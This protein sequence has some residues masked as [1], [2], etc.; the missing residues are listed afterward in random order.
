MNLTKCLDKHYMDFLAYL[1]GME[2]SGLKLYDLLGAVRRGEL[3]IADCYVF[4]AR[5]YDILEGSLGDP[6]AALFKLS[7][8]IQGSKL[9][10]LLRG[11]GSALF[12][13]GDTGSF[14]TAALKSE[15]SFFRTK[16]S[17][18]LRLIEVL[19]E[20]ML[21]A[22]LCVSMFSILPIWPLPPA[23]GVLVLQS[24][25]L[26]GFTVANRVARKLLYS[27]ETLIVLLEASYIV[28]S[29]VPAMFTYYGL[30]AY[31]L[32]IVFAHFLIHRRL[33][34][35][36]FI[37][38]ESLRVL[39]DVH[40]YVMLG[41]MPDVALLSALGGAQGFEFRVMQH[42]LLNGLFG[43]EI[44]SKLRLPGLANDI[45]HKLTSLMHYSAFN[46]AYVASIMQYADEISEVR[47]LA[48]VKAKN[49]LLYS[50]VISFL[51]IASYIM[52]SKIP[53]LLNINPKVL[54]LYGFTSIISAIAP[55]CILKDRSFMGSRTAVVATTTAT[56]IP[57]LFN[58][59]P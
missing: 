5:L 41:E 42:G 20:A 21:A 7:E 24:I 47:K 32:F 45:M 22:I 33:K 10:G 37:E 30:A 40:S 17:E 1:H 6:K 31:L 26:M 53:A 3:K 27:R 18:E 55:T 19:Y 2:V 48:E 28:L 57:L 39:R 38:R 46:G 44:V 52:I 43:R 15:F 59:M 51:V 58:I 23:I 34:N 29:I 13:S 11:Y 49:Y 25:G 16:I 50:I 8:F 14:V 36:V 35:E 54:G 9:V 4:I 56:A 12:T